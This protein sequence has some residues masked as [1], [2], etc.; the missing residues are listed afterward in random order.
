[1]SGNGIEFHWI[2]TVQTADGLQGSFDGQINAVPGIHT[3]TSS[4]NVVRDHM[5]DNVGTSQFA[6]LF[7][8]LEPNALG[9]AA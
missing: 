8:L 5:A 1:M 6:V 9:G 7:F 2:M 4:Y 3:H